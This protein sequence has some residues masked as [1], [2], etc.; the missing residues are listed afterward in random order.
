MSKS[1]SRVEFQA[2]VIGE[3]LADEYQVNIPCKYPLLTPY[4]LLQCA[5]SLSLNQILIS[6]IILV[7]VYVLIGFDVSVSTVCSYILQYN[8][9]MNTI[10]C[11]PNT[12]RY[13]WQYLHHWCT[14]HVGK[15]VINKHYI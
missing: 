11:S 2:T 1:L 13:D 8:I 3:K 4:K 6:A 7:W 9:T 10:D 14:L 15:G 12:G 5:P